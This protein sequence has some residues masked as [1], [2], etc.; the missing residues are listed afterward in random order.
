MPEYWV[1]FS[2]FL[3]HRTFQVELLAAVAQRLQA[4]GIHVNVAEWN[5]QAGRP[6][7]DGKIL[8][9]LRASDCLVVI[10][11]QEAATSPDIHQEIGAMWG[12]GKPVIGFLQD[13][14]SPRGTLVGKE[15][16]NFNYGNL[17]AQLEN[18]VKH[19]AAWRKRKQSTWTNFGIAGGAA[20]LAGIFLQYGDKNEK[21][22]ERSSIQN[23]RKPS[24]ADRLLTV[25]EAAQ[26][27]GYSESSIRRWI[28]EGDLAFGEGDRNTRYVS[29][30]ELDLFLISSGRA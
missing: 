29:K 21:G 1:P 20:L 11:T 2:V 24:E 3:S 4:A 19:L 18:L 30:K 5:P 10:M 15:Y 22:T 9:L 16:V 25:A 23:K 13:G 6:L 14:Q 12:S 8:E 28:R 26:Y 17:D 27:S 7:Y